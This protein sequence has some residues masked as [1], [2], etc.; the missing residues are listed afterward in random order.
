MVSRFPPNTTA[1]RQVRLVRQVILVRLVRLIRQVKLVRQVRLV[2]QVKLVIP[3]IK[4][5]I[6][7]YKF[8]TKVGP[9]RM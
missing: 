6:L 3:T 2:R 7:N 4:T 1:G 5:A 9:P 8:L